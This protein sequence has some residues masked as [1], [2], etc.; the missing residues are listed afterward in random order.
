MQLNAYT[1][2]MHDFLK[3]RGWHTINPT[4]FIKSLVIESAEILEIFQWENL[5]A[6]EIK[7]N[8]VKM[9]RVENELADVFMYSF[10]VCALLGL[11]AEKLINTR[12]SEEKVPTAYVEESRCDKRRPRLVR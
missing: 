5:S 3:S 11:D 9:D 12:A 6:A 10:D 8:K 4:D 2:K 1:K 7:K